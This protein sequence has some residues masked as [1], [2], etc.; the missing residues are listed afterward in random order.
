MMISKKPFSKPTEFRLEQQSNFDYNEFKLNNMMV[1]AKCVIS[2]L[3][4]LSIAQQ[5]AAQYLV[6]YLLIYSNYLSII[7][8]CGSFCRFLLIRSETRLN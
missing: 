2:L 4:A 6:S 7:L 5:N 3:I 8:I 1:D